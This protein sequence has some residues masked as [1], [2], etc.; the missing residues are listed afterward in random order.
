MRTAEGFKQLQ[1]SW[2][3]RTNHPDKKI[4]DNKDF[5]LIR[6]CPNPTC[7]R[8][9]EWEDNC[10]HMTCKGK[11][12]CTHQYCHVCLRKWYTCKCGYC[13]FVGDAAPTCSGSYTQNCNVAPLQTNW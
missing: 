4:G 9:N 7:A 13:T 10:K 11:S 1:D 5:P 6:V 3:D 12:G 8:I 2:N